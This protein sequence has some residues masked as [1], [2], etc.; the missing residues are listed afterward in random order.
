VLTDRH[1]VFFIDGKNRRGVG[2]GHGRFSL[3]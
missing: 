1:E 2:N 3:C